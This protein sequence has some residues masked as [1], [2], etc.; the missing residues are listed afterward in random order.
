MYQLFLVLPYKY[1]FFTLYSTC[2]VKYFQFFSMVIYIIY[3]I[4]FKNKTLAISTVTN[5]S[6]DMLPAHTEDCQ[7][8]SIFLYTLG[9]I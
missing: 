7:N 5:L 3:I 6:F 2:N 8:I 1:K 4:L 9:P